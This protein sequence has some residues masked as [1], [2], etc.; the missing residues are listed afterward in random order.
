MAPKVGFL[1]SDGATLQ[2]VRRQPILALLAAVSQVSQVAAGVTSNQHV[3]PAHTSVHVRDGA[4]G[5][6]GAHLII[7]V[8]TIL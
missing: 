2:A 6:Y 1:L 3:A 4:Q 7:F 8:K 5:C